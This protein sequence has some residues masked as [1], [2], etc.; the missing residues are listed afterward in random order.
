MPPS[1]IAESSGYR[2]TSTH[3]E[4]MAY[5]DA[6]ASMGR[7]QLRVGS[8]GATPNGREIPLLVLSS[9]GVADP[10]AARA[11]GR[12]VVLLQNC[13]HAGEVEG[14]EAAL[15]LTRDLLLGAEDGLLERVTVLV[16]PVFNP[17]G[18]D[19]MDTTNRA[20]D[21]ARLTGQDGPAKVGTRVN[22]K[23]IN[24]NRDYIRHD[25]VEMQ[26]LQTR[27]AQPWQPELTIDTHATNG[28]VHRFAMTYD[29][30]HTV[31]SGRAE[32]ITYMREVLT[33]AINAAVKS[34]YELDS[35]WY[36]NFVEDE[37]VLDAA[38]VADPTSPIG[39]G[40]MTYPHHPRFGSNYRGLGNRLD[41]L[42]ECYS[43]L[44]YEA[45][46][47]TTYAWLRESLKAVAARADEVRDNV[48]RWAAPPE[49]VAVRYQLQVMPEPVRILTRSPRTREGTPGEVTI[50]HLARFVGTHVVRRPEAYVVPGHLAGF[51][52]GHGLTVEPAPAEAVVTVGRFA[53]MSHAG[54]RKILEAAGHG[55]RQVEW[56]APAAQKLSGDAVIVRTEQPLG[57][58]AVYL[59]E[60]ESDDGIYENGLLT[61][62][63][64]GETLE[65]CRLVD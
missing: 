12:P 30:P 23:G 51:L 58:L 27:L 42:L 60:P 26:L 61:T 46:V 50:P 33:P 31:A 10:A 56:S 17:D 28:S 13:I 19:A 34:G 37:R 49:D 55:V 39:E 62:P 36:G 48:A 38:G 57:A 52:R 18:N 20:L 35:G 54:G 21:I 53:G 63:A 16:L 43:Y 47:R 24:L 4:V 14:K 32:P 11:L 9:E 1:T 41:L 59:C 3:A 7:P 40:W 64:E 6:L 45:R 25:T 29:I 44:P 2:A 8:I 22:A 65:V 15:A 5:I